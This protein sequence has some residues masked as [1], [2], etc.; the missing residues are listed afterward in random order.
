VHNGTVYRWNRP[1]YGISPNGKPHLRI[2]NRILGA[3]PTVLDEM[4]NTAFW[5]GVMEGMA[6]EYGDITQHLGFEDALDNFTKGART[7]IDSKFTWVGNEKVAARDLTLEMLLPLARKGLDKRQINPEHRDQYLG[8]IEERAR[9]HMNGARWILMTY[10]KFMKETNHDESATSLTAAI[11]HNQAKTKPAH[12]WEIPQ[13]HEFDQYD[14]SG[15]LVEE[16][17]STDIFTVRKEDIVEFAAA[18][19]AW[20]NSEYLPVE[21]GAGKLVG[22]VTNKLILECFTKRTELMPIL[23]NDGS[24]DEE[25]LQQL[26]QQ[27]NPD[28]TAADASE[29]PEREQFVHASCAF[30]P[31]RTVGDIML[32]SP[33]T[34]APQTTIL[35]VISLMNQHQIRV[36]PVVKN[37]ELV[38][39]ISEKDFM[40]ICKRLI[41]RLHGDKV[42]SEK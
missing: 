26:V 23:H 7:G 12:T 20:S 18:L 14:P 38:G 5:L 37:E 31:L 21:D 16:F 13:L 10:T 30:V 19:M 9:R 35:E 4:A 6:E 42:K 34:I 29:A 25:K 3:G 32:R 28:D 15:L 36:L 8:I 22:L 2:E 1:C 33:I 39:V 24:T 41:Q 40:V 27:L 17:M 11:W